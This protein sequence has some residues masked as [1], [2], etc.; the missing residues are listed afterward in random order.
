MSKRAHL[1][2]ESDNDSMDS[3][4]LKTDA[5]SIEKTKFG[6]SDVLSVEH[7][8]GL[9][10]TGLK[11]LLDKSPTE[12]ELNSLKEDPELAKVPEVVLGLNRSK[13]LLASK[14]KT[15]HTD[16][17]LQKVFDNIINFEDSLDIDHKK[18]EVAILPE[19]NTL[20]FSKATMNINGVPP[21]PEIKS[22]AI[23]AQVFMHKSVIKQKLFLSEADAMASHNERLEFIGDSFL[24]TIMT[25]IIVNEFPSANEGELSLVR[26]KLVN[27]QVLQKWSQLY[28]LDKR[29]KMNVDESVFK[30]KLKIYADV[31][32]AYI[33]GLILESPSNYSVVLEWL[34]EL[35]QPILTAFRDKQAKKST[36][37]NRSS[38]CPPTSSSTFSEATSTATRTSTTGTGTQLN[39]L[40]S[41]NTSSSETTPLNPNAK[42]DLYSLIGYAKLGLRYENMG[43]VNTG[44][45]NITVFT[46]QVK[47]KDG[48]ILGEGK[49]KNVKEAGARA[50]MAA[51][52]NKPLIEKYSL[53]RASI[54]RDLSNKPADVERST[55]KLQKKEK[56]DAGF[57]PVI[58]SI[59]H[60]SK[61]QAE[62]NS[63]SQDQNFDQLLE[64]LKKKTLEEPGTSTNQNKSYK[65]INKNQ[66]KNQNGNNNRS[67]GFSRPNQNYG[68]RF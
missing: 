36:G 55:Q 3:K 7:A 5:S 32:E 23:R 13:M 54:P 38:S 46:V 62:E 58:N 52:A 41:S 14:L 15:L 59:D 65:S 57:K 1:E 12:E 37:G 42:V 68:D 17:T 25:Q 47:T 26:T 66:N 31:F 9:V 33:G 60:K 4:R 18:V 16:G 27:N 39:E 44:I 45:D 34:R 48:D 50:A 11:T 49:G 20:K 6:L 63:K 53:L 43:H 10:Q 29:L 64:A 51:L 8:V 40:T 24:N 21:I 22:N 35:A 56:R 67:N 19:S 2:S 61:L 28:G 30:G